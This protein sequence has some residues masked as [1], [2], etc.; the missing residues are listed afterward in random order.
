MTDFEQDL[1]A[2]VDTIRNGGVILY[3]TDTVWGL[4]CDA[5]NA[6]A[7]ARIYA[8][9]KRD[10]SKALIVLAATEREVLQYTAAVD[11]SLF[12]YLET[13]E[14]PTTV[15]YEHGIGFAEN[16][17]AADGSIAIRICKDDFC[18]SLIKRFGKPIVSTSANIS[19]EPTPARFNAITAA[20]KN[21]AD[22]IVQYRQDD[23]T[24]HQ[25]S[26]IIR[27]KDGQVE[28]IR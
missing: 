2:A 7:V 13:A 11:L 3:P 10:D 6:E 23:R 14:R 20:I 16:L 27:W 24:P 15:I 9:K 26:S 25:P 19:G 18:R 12:D 8:I 1:K 28:V 4:G 17:T 5:T 21:Q 22:Y